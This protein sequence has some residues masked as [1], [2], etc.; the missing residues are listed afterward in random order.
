MNTGSTGGSITAASRRDNPIT[1]M[2]G[3]GCSKYT[4]AS[5]ACVPGARAFDP[6]EA[7]ETWMAGTSPAMTTK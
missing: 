1:V 5:L 2:P 6:R 7:V 3:H 4:I